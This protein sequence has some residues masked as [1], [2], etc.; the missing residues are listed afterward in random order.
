M[1]QEGKGGESSGSRQRRPPLRKGGNGDPPLRQRPVGEQPHPSSESAHHKG[2]QNGHGRFE[3]GRF[4]NGKFENGP[5]W[6]TGGKFEN[7]KGGLRYDARDSY[8]DYNGY[9]RGR[10]YGDSK[11]HNGK[12]YRGG[13]DYHREFDH[14]PSPWPAQEAEQSLKDLLMQVAPQA[15]IA[16]NTSRLS[17]K[18]S[19]NILSKVL[20]EAANSSTQEPGASAAGYSA[21]G[22]AGYDIP[23]GRHSNGAS[24]PKPEEDDE[25]AFMEKWSGLF[26]RGSP[27]VEG[28]LEDP[29]SDLKKKSNVVWKKSRDR[30]GH[31][32]RYQE[33]KQQREKEK[34]TGGAGETYADYGEAYADYDE[35]SGAA[36]S[37]QQWLDQDAPRTQWR[38]QRPPAE[39]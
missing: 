37:P 22:A 28:S 39:Y 20:S 32:R 24:R 16:E 23:S 11:G 3:N 9:G 36:A 34:E 19:A 31:R 17:S 21:K 12:G 30:E 2:G 6:K 7:G 1:A 25:S 18:A 5:D 15:R 33:R 38:P 8:S 4:E 29:F 35:A 13:R 10:G 27:L 14:G 26:S